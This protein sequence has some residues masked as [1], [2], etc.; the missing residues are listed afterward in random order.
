MAM[1]DPTCQATIAVATR[2]SSPSPAKFDGGNDEL[3]TP[4][5]FVSD[6]NDSVDSNM[7]IVALD[8]DLVSSPTCTPRSHH[9]QPKIFLISSGN[10]N[11]NESTRAPSSLLTNHQ[12]S[13]SYNKHTVAIVEFH[14]YKKSCIEEEKVA[15][16][17]RSFSHNRRP[18]SASR[19]RGEKVGSSPPLPTSVVVR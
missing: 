13:M 4:F 8:L 15:S 6:T 1:T 7:Q 19:Q 10:H 16:R 2:F 14:H 12:P 17:S 11:N 3:A 9:Q 18:F 5:S